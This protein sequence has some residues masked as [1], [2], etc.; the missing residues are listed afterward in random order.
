MISKLFTD[1][2]FTWLLQTFDFFPECWWSWFFSWV[3][4]VNDKYSTLHIE[5]LD[6]M[7]CLSKQGF[8]NQHCTEPLFDCS[9]IITQRHWK[10]Q[11]GGYKFKGRIL[12]LS[13][14][15]LV[16]P[17]FFPLKI[18]R[19]IFFSKFSCLPW[20]LG[21]ILHLC[22]YTSKRLPETSEYK[23]VIWEVT[24]FNISWVIYIHWS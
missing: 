3:K 12:K 18:D 2:L 24:H 15:I 9:S 14:Y 7:R 22:I 5:V 21:G 17:F 1:I 13:I 10:V 8:R 23:A 11:W 4:S 20:N 19:W 16:V 6:P